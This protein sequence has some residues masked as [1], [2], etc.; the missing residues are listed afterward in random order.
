M[1]REDR[2]EAI[3]EELEGLDFRTLYDTHDFS[4]AL[5]ETGRVA[6]ELLDEVQRL[7][8]FEDR[9][10]RTLEEKRLQ[11]IQVEGDNNYAYDHDLSMQ[12][13]VS[14]EQLVRLEREIV[15]LSSLFEKK[16]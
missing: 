6:L 10:V 13:A 14:G 4:V 1:L 3:R 16:G 2:L 7:K 12:Y 11:R 15:V 8:G 5:A 9:V